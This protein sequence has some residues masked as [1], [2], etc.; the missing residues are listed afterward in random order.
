MLTIIPT[1]S[2]NIIANERFPFF[3]FRLVKKG[4]QVRSAWV[5]KGNQPTARINK[6]NVYFTYCYVMTPPSW[7]AVSERECAK[8]FAAVICQKARSGQSINSS[9]LLDFCLSSEIC[10]SFF[11][12]SLTQ[13]QLQSNTNTSTQT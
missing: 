3:S 8:H 10:I 11:F 6:R 7:G 12:T 5:L 13:A 4:K 2:A 1:L 9:L